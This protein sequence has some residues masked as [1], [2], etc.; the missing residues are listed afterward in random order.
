MII[1]WLTAAPSQLW[2]AIHVHNKSIFSLNSYKLNLS[3]QVKIM[4]RLKDKVAVTTGGNSG[5]GLATSQ[6]FV[7]EGA[8]VFI[9]P[10]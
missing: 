9:T 7:A 8:Y 5:I 4:E 3:T 6:R 10:S 1:E 2:I